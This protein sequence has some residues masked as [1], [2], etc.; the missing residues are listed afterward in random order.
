MRGPG[1]CLIRMDLDRFYAEAR[2]VLKPGGTLAVWGY[3]L[4]RFDIPAADDVM[5][6]LFNG[7]LGP[8]WDEGRRLVDRRYQGIPCFNTCL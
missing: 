5:Q 8:Y 3:E 7:T 4:M 6:G 2:R 1:G